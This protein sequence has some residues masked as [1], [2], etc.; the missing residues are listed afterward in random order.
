[1]NN[2]SRLTME[3]VFLPT[4]TFEKSYK[5]LKKKYLS[6]KSDLEDFK[7][8]YNENPDIGRNLGGGFRKIRV[9]IKSKNRGKSGGARI[10]AYNDMF[11]KAEENIVILVE[12]YDKGEIST[13][14]ESEFVTIL[15]EFLENYSPST[16]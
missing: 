5:R 4:P 1:M 16:N 10:I 14:L 11:I 3:H 12:I 6:L 8:E 15:R 7:K 13:L 9:A 2:N